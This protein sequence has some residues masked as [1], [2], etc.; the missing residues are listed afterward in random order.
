MKLFVRE[1]NKFNNS[2]KSL[3]VI[4]PITSETSV[5][6]HRTLSKN[7][8]PVYPSEERAAKAISNVVKFNRFMVL[9]KD[10]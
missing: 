2:K 5:K 3:I 6:V 4:V 8:I 9:Q 10:I 1:L 7:G